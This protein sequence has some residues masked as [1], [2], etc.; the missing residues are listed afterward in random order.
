MCSSV[1]PP[2]IRIEF[3]NPATEIDNVTNLVFSEEAGH[4]ILCFATGSPPPEV[5]EGKQ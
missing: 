3:G 2:E 4:E 5:R 1:V